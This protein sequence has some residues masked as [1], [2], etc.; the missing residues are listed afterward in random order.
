M[1]G[2][3]EWSKPLLQV[4][5][6]QNLIQADNDNYFVTAANRQVDDFKSNEFYLSD[7]DNGRELH[8]T[9]YYRSYGYI[10]DSCS[11][12]YQ[13]I[14]K[15]FGSGADTFVSR[16]PLPVNNST[17]TLFKLDHQ[18]DLVWAK[19]FKGNMLSGKS[20]ATTPDGNWLLLTYQSSGFYQTATFD[21]NGVFLDSISTPLTEN[22]VTLYKINSRGDI[23]WEKKIED[24][25]HPNYYTNPEDNPDVA[26][27]AVTSNHICIQTHKDYIV[28]DQSGNQVQ[29]R[30][31]GVYMCSANAYSITSQADLF[32]SIGGE[33]DPSTYYRRPYLQVSR[34][35]GDVSSHT[36]PEQLIT[37]SKIDAT[38]GGL[39][40]SE[41]K[42]VAKYS[43]SG[44][45][46]WDIQI[47][48]LPFSHI[49]YC[50][51]PSCSGG[52]ILFKKNSTGQNELI[53]T[54]ANGKY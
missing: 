11:P 52:V 35:N 51:T 33:F 38:I 45:L 24:I 48:R 32:Y 36:F 42:N 34:S 2:H 26:S 20:L 50:A 40:L 47:S 49:V 14:N 12:L 19:Y 21:Q 27:L 8:L 18:G 16:S 44:T 9:F 28:L 3:L 25:Y 54:D 39:I 37:H 53:K 4:G 43:F 6:M 7:N 13:R 1:M 31:P 30:R 10:L 46:L 15:N 41:E 17:C 23:L 5:T 22:T 29:R